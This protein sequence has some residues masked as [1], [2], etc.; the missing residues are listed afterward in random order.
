VAVPTSS[1]PPRPDPGDP[2]ESDIV[3]VV[4]AGG[5]SRR[6]GTDKALLVVDGETL[7]ERAIRTLGAAGA[8][9][10]VIAS[11]PSRRYDVAT[12][13]VV[14]PPGHEGDGPLA[15]LAA[16]FAHLSRFPARPA[17]QAPT[18]AG[19]PASV[20]LVVAVDLP[21]ADP[22]LLRRLADLVRTGP[23]LA[24]VPLDDTGRPQPLH[25]AYD[26]DRAGPVVAAALDRGERRVLRVVLDDLGA[27]TVEGPDGAWHRN[28]NRPDDLA[29]P[30]SDPC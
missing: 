27:T 29:P 14:D 19:K 17:V 11:G 30:T 22:A 4:L 15:G 21:D 26:V 6:M 8:T 28:V 10:I 1:P 12:T 9:T 16:A 2:N 23:A 25:A 7:L 5:A 18:R 24:A 13:Q 3:G 20:A